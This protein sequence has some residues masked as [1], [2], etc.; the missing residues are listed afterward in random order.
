MKYRSNV[1]FLSPC[2]CL[3]FICFQTVNFNKPLQINVIRTSPSSLNNAVSTSHSWRQ[4]CYKPQITQP[5]VVTQ[6]SKFCCLYL[7]F[8]A[9]CTKRHSSSSLTL[10]WLYGCL[11]TCIREVKQDGF[12]LSITLHFICLYAKMKKRPMVHLKDTHLFLDIF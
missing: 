8:I 4:V 6:R 2:Q 3:S 12:L 9:L 7:V 10:Y 5:P 11:H 1:N